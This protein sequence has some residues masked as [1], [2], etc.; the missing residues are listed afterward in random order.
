MKINISL[1]VSLALDIS[2]R[3][4]IEYSISLHGKFIETQLPIK[5][6]FAFEYDIAFS[7]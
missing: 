5:W 6:R 4:L 7:Y 2:S 1:Q 3:Y